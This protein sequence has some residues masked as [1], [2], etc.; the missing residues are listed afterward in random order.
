MSE[1][2]DYK[3][4]SKY[5]KLKLIQEN[6]IYF[7]E[8]NDYAEYLFALWKNDYKT[9]DFFEHFGNKPTTIIRNYRSYKRNLLMGF[10]CKDL[11]ENG[12]LVKPILLEK[13]TII[14]F[15]HKKN[16][17][18]GNDI[19]LAKGINGKWTY[20]YA[21]TSNSGGSHSGACPWGEIFDS[22][23]KTIEAACLKMITWHEREKCSYSNKVI[24]LAKDK[25]KEVKTPMQLE[26]NLF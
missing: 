9:I 15:R 24:S 17:A 7:T 13:E 11:D 16:F 12:W 8:R 3:D 2:E 4:L 21:F 22:K 6:R 5:E 23:E 20:G 19:T 14:I 18:Y 26:L 1:N 10:D 25:I